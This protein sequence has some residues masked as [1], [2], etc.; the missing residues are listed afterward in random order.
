MRSIR[1]IK[2][3]FARL[4]LRLFMGKRSRVEGSIKIPTLSS[5][6][7][8][9]RDEY[10]IPTISAQDDDAAWY[11]LG[12]CHAQDRAGQ[13][14]FLRRA[15]RGDLSEIVGPETLIID[16]IARRLGF[17]RSAEEQYYSIDSAARACIEAYAA[18]VNAGFEH[19]I[20]GVPHELALLG[21]SLTPWCAT[22]VL[23]Y[24]KLQSFLLPSNWDVELARFKIASLDGI[25]AV[26]ALDPALTGSP[27]HVTPDTI[28]RF[29]HAVDRLTE[30]LALFAEVI[31]VGGGSNNWVIA[32]H[33]TE[34]GR[35][36]LANDPH[37]NPMLPAPWY[38]AQIRTPEWSLTGATTPGAP[39]FPAGHNG[40]A[41]WGST[42]A[43]HDN[44]DFFME[45]L[46]E[47]RTS[48]RNGDTWI[49]CQSIIEKIAVRN[50]ED[51]IEHIL[52]T[53]RG[54]IVSEAFDGISHALSVRSVWL[55]PLPIRGFLDV[56]R[57][58]SFSE[59][60]DCFRQWPLMGQYLVYAD[61]SGT[62]AWQLVGQV[63]ERERGWGMLPQ[64]GR[65]SEVPWKGLV[66]FDEMPCG[67]DPRQNFFATANNAP[68]HD[69]G[70]PYLGYDWVCGYRAAQLTE[71]LLGRDDWTVAL[72][73]E[74]QTQQVSKPWNDV[75]A[76]VL[77]VS[78]S[79][80]LASRALRILRDWDG[81]LSSDSIGASTYIYFF[82]EFAAYAAKAKA[83]LSWEFALG[84][85]FGGLVPFTLFADRRFEHVADLLIRK[86]P[87]W[88]DEPWNVVLNT[89]L[90]NAIMRLESDSGR[91][92]ELA[93]WG[94][95]RQFLFKHLVAGEIKGVQ[96]AFNRGP[97]PG[98]GDSNTVFQATVNPLRPTEAP[99]NIPNLRMVIDVGDWAQSQYVL[100]GGQSGN[101]LSPQYDDLLGLWTMG[102][103]VSIPW[104]ETEINEQTF[105]QTELI[106][107]TVPEKS[108]V[109]RPGKYPSSNAVA[110]PESRDYY[111]RI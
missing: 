3:T 11:A 65:I 100:C 99:T 54:P 67:M 55:D 91:P 42:A 22:D 26:K 45:E 97:I 96:H 32:G 2:T 20:R 53:P 17:R 49:Q 36:L 92:A 86:P 64:L 34:S 50:A 39:C 13:L 90:A 107:A 77:D 87:D 71:A 35:P 111:D 37:L 48:V 58:R 95:L 84:K 102:R 103:A 12:F 44:T 14:E 62:I 9:R 21:T 1:P 31:P 18:G 101:P 78:P 85:G 83:P 72:C 81:R 98:S 75:K 51:V 6:V 89:V 16:R 88:F 70:G 74:L 93:A 43:L 30:D 33:K 40:Y 80:D 68:V 4:F 29:T 73:L 19:G 59:F 23:T 24:I 82:C 8:I 57:A 63:P 41:A 61:I 76:A 5:R 104:T 56:Q 60:R 15:A 38:L 66:P 79:S 110:L 27:P 108:D 52:I 109:K 10:G 69:N 25:E 105:E 28:E 94:S 7:L 46:S 47:D 106:P